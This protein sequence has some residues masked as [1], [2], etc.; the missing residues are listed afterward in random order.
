MAFGGAHGITRVVLYYDGEWTD[1]TSDQN[2]WWS[3]QRAKYSCVC[4]S[5]SRQ[6]NLTATELVIDKK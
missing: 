6:Q 4:F 1:S 5:E 2:A 3:T